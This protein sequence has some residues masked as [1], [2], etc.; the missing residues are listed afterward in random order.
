M[1]S[2]NDMFVLT[3]QL[4]YNVNLIISEQIKFIEHVTIPYSTQFYLCTQKSWLVTYFF[5]IRFS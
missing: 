4:V 1:Y 3:N 5:C 2:P